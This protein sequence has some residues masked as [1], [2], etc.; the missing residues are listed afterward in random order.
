MIGALI[1]WSIGA[2][3]GRD[4]VPAEIA[5]SW[6]LTLLAAAA[7]LGC[8]A[9]FLHQRMQVQRVRFDDRQAVSWLALGKAAAL[10]GSLMAGGYVGFAI[11]FLGQLQVEGPRER[12]V[13]SLVAIIASIAITVAALRI[14][15]ACMVPPS[16]DDDE[17]TT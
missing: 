12:V 16:D 15:R 1:G 14:E 10:L 7:A 17:E 9:F 3:T 13:R 2:L 8:I 6:P 11:R 5:W 4:G